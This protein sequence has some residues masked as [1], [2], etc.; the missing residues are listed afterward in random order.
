VALGQIRE[1]ARKLKAKGALAFQLA[2]EEAKMAAQI[3]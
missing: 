3:S 1:V 2:D